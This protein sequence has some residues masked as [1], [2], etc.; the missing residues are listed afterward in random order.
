MKEH[1]LPYGMS[2][3]GFD[4]MDEF[5]EYQAKKE[6][7]ANAAVVSLQRE[8]GYGSYVVRLVPNLVIWGYISALEEVKAAERKY[9]SDPF[10]EG[11]EDE[12]NG[13]IDG[14]TD[15]FKRGYR[16][17]RFYSEVEPAGELGDAHISTLWPITEKD[18]ERAR[19]N[20][21]QLWPELA[22]RLKAQ[23]EEAKKEMKRR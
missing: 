8:I 5:W 23:F 12:Y 2:V 15:R 21:W 17:G 14:V 6:A 16:Y 10:G 22:D 19:R 9:Y 18:F 13:I 20:R 4:T 1:D 7:Q 11:E 3:V